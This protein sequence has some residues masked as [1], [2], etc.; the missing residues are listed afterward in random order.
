MAGVIA[1]SGGLFLFAAML[2]LFFPY[3][4]EHDLVRRRVASV[5]ARS[6]RLDLLDEELSKP[7]SERLFKPLVQKLFSKY[8]KVA[9]KNAGSEHSAN[10][11][12]NIRLKKKLRQAGLSISVSEYSFFRFIVITGTAFLFGITA[13][14]LG[15]GVRSLLYALLGLYAGFAVMRFQLGGKVSK[16]RTAMEKQLPD[17]LDLLS[18]NVEAGL[19]F[20]QALCHVIG[21]FEGPIIEELT[22]TYREM[23]MG[24][25]RRDALSLFAE[26]CDLNDVKTFVGSMIQAD[27]LGISIK[28]VLRTQASAMRTSRR[29]K[30]EE[31]AMKVSVKILLPMVGLIF[32]VLLIVLMGPAAIKIISVFR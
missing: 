20:E 23:T 24:R 5:T 6:G 14:L 9:G 30:V 8:R 12:R 2:L 26:R 32:P 19:G 18:V 4:K 27:Q 13:A 25:P 1:L 7:L 28:N 11:P 21:H 29:N 22:V 17:V 16:R 31:K 15:L 3:G 10:S